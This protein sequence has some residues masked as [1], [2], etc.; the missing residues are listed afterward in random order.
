[1]TR[2]TLPLFPS[3]AVLYPGARLPLRI[4]ERR[5]VDLVRACLRENRG[6]GIPP[7]RRGNEAG[8]PATPWP[9]GTLALIRDFSQG[10]DGL[11]HLEVE[12]VRRFRLHDHVPGPDGVLMGE[13]SWLDADP[14]SIPLQAD[15]DLRAVLNLLLEAAPLPPSSAA[16]DSEHL[17]YRLLERLPVPVELQVE[18]LLEDNIGHQLARCRDVLASLVTQH[19]PEAL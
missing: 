18:I 6:F 19:R 8:V 16:V 12:G 3:R 11:L 15:A 14:L 5:Y 2:E 4:F 1:M 10:A 17:V 9:G 13:V 7:I